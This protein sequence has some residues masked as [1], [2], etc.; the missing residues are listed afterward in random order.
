MVGK[1]KK[2]KHL[3]GA[4]VGENVVSKASRLLEQLG[5]PW[6]TQARHC[7]VPGADGIIMAKGRNTQQN[8]ILPEIMHRRDSGR[9]HTNVTTVVS[10]LWGVPGWWQAGGSHE[11][12]PWVVL[13]TAET[14]GQ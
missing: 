3:A 7:S 5:T 13:L 8:S 11:A 6:L 1:K 14:V 12:D 10:D 9:F 2:N 4:G